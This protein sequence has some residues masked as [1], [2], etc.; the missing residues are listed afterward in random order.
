MRLKKKFVPQKF[1]T[2]LPGFLM[3]RPGLEMLY[4]AYSEF[5]WLVHL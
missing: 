5:T 3:V 2:P 4:V 1:Y